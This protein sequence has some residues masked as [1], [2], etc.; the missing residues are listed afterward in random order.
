[1]AQLTV[2]TGAIE[3]NVKISSIDYV[4]LGALAIEQQIRILHLENIS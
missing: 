2:C 3:G 4:K 1:V